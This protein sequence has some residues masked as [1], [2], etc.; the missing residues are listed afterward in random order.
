MQKPLSF[1]LKI[2]NPY[3]FKNPKPLSLRSYNFNPLKLF[4]TRIFA[5]IDLIDYYYRFSIRPKI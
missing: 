5:L 4:K 1:K 3:V 2:S